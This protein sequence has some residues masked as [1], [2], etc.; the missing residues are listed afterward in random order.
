MANY[1][2]KWKTDFP[3]TIN[4]QN[5]PTEGIDNSLAF[6]TD[7]FPQR[8]TS[9]PVHAK[10]E[11]DMASQLFSNDE[12][13][14]ES[15]EAASATESNHEKDTAAH[16]NGIA[17]NAKSATKLANARTIQTNLASTT[18]ASFDGTA[19]V[20]LGVTGILPVS[21]GG[22][23][24]ANG[25]VAKLT[26]ARAI[27]TNLA[28]TAAASFDGSSNITPGVTGVLPVANG[29]TG[30][31]SEKYVKLTGDTM[32][33]TLELK[34]TDKAG[35][36]PRTEFQND[37]FNFIGSDGNRYGFIRLNHKT[38]GSHTLSITSVNTSNSPS[39]GITIKSDTS[40]NT[41]VINGKTPAS[42][43]SGDE[44]VTAGWVRSFSNA[45]KALIST[46]PAADKI[47]YFTGT[48]DAALTTL[49]SFARTILDDTSA[50]AVR[51]TIGANAQ[52]CG[53]IVAANLAENGYAKWAN[54]LI[55]QW[56]KADVGSNEQTIKFNIAYTS[57]YEG[58]CTDNGNFTLGENAIWCFIKDTN[59]QFKTG[60]YW[61]KEKAFSGGIVHWI[62]VGK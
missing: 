61:P 26:N 50:S 54:G 6:N 10:L 8:I 11:N 31:T 41:I 15:I 40:G 42:S 34:V 55:I 27:Q 39:S 46:T 60:G 49:S 13:L 43:V 17:G 24:N 32:T 12:R 29:G 4:N 20:T 23:G 62:S 59:S 25:T 16:A 58:V 28:S 45:L 14:K 21:S 37:F 53:G 1:L 9:D 35:T 19:N 18:A 36:A 51:S 52:N 22:T 48:S 30:S 7:G 44:I 2:D 57:F 33:G 3:E 56:G 38:D 5:R 47:P